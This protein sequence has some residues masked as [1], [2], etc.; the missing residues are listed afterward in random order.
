M[1]VHHLDWEAPLEE[2]MA[3]H[4]IILAWR[5][6]WT[7]EPGGLQPMGWHE[8]DISEPLSPCACVDVGEAAVRK[9]PFCAAGLCMMPA[10]VP[11]GINGSLVSCGLRS[12]HCFFCRV[13][14]VPGDTQQE[15]VNESSDIGGS[16]GCAKW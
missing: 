12:Q 15:G 11:A 10:L 9:S 8:L 13:G 4:S 2:G 16:E 1:Q 7:E 6:P 3:K 5:I 14:V